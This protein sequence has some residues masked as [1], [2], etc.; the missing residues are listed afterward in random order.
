MSHPE[1]LGYFNLVAAANTRLIQDARI[2]EVGSYDVN[3]SIR[4]IFAA[5]R[6]YVGVDLTEGP[7]VDLVAFGHEV[8]HPT[9]AY[10][11]T[12]SGECFEHDPHWAETFANMARLTRSGGLMA[13][14]CASTGR[15]EHGTVRTDLTLS[16]GT[17]AQGLDYYRNLTASDFEQLALSEWFSTWRFWY[18]PTSFDL[19]FSGVR[20][21]AEADAVLPAAPA[22]EN[23]RTLMSLPHKLVRLPLRGLAQILPDDRY[24]T[25]IRPYWKLLLRLGGRFIRAPRTQAS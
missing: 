11:I 8:D 17:Q 15:P 6:E 16:P 1:Q 23:L 19:Y 5:A 2:L 7:G 25:L 13:F 24:Q 21:G 22:V 12:I 18:L 9:G 10:D 3:G 20:A 14:T 4:A